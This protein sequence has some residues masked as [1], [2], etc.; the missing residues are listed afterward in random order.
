MILDEIIS[1][2]KQGKNILIFGNELF[3]KG[4]V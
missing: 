3:D 1:S 4:E 2:V